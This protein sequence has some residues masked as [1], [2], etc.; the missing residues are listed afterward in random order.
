MLDNDG[1]GML[2][3]SADRYI[4]AVKLLTTGKAKHLL[5]SGGN[6]SLLDR[7]FSEADWTKTQLKD[8]NFPDT[9]ILI[10]DRS[11]NTMENASYSKVILA[12]AHLKPPYLLVTSAFHMRRSMMIFQHQGINVV[13]YPANYLVDRGDISFS[14]FLPDGSS[15]LAWNLYTKELV[16]YVIDYFKVR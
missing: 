15:L 10:E 5:M 12:R 14:D 1:N 16:G 13:P 6:G 11:R 9:S 4:E 7:R 3:I 2:N 8:F